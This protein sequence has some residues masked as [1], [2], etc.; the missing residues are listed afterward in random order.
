M[1]RTTPSVLRAGESGEPLAGGRKN[2]WKVD[3]RRAPNSSSS[4]SQSMMMLPRVRA[5]RSRSGSLTPTRNAA[6]RRP[7]TQLH[8]ASAPPEGA[9]SPLRVQILGAEQQRRPAEP[10]PWRGAEEEGRCA[11]RLGERTELNLENKNTKFALNRTRRGKS[12]AP[13]CARAPLLHPP[14]LPQIREDKWRTWTVS[15]IF[16]GGK[17]GRMQIIFSAGPTIA[18]WYFHHFDS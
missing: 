14:P 15:P 7:N 4:R 18:A 16:S 10:R 6:A 8:Q 12:P 1:V 2:P 11:H 17:K 3:P 5:P 9:S 13:F